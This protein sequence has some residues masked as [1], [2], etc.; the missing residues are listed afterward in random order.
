MGRTIGD[1]LQDERTG[2]D[3]RDG[4]AFTFGQ[5]GTE[6]RA[7]RVAERVFIGGDRNLEWEG[8]LGITCKMNKQKSIQETGMPLHFWAFRN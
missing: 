1:H 2:I 4:I 3:S 6:T 8:P 7:K 5:S